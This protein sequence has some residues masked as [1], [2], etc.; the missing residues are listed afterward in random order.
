MPPFRLDHV[1]HLGALEVF[2]L[3]KWK[4]SLDKCEAGFSDAVFLTLADFSELREAT[5]ASSWRGV[6]EDL[7][8]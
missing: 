6:L 3:V 2:L 5:H 8:S 4:I 1:F 7:F